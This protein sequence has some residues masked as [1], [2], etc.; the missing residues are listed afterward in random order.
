MG[1]SVPSNVPD[2]DLD[3]HVADLILKEAKQKA[4]NY[5]TLGIKAY[6]PAVYARRSIRKIDLMPLIQPR[7]ECTSP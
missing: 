7:P 5:S 3:K 4:E 2:E 1:A 6:L